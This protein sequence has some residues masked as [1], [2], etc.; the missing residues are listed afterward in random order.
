M[1]TRFVARTNVLARMA[2]PV[3]L[4]AGLCACSSMPDWVDPTGWFGSDSQADQTSDAAPDAAQIADNAQTP[5]LASIPAKPTAP[6]TPDEQKQ[7][8]E[9][10]AADRT[11]AQYSAEALEGGT[12]P[13]APP[14]PANDAAAPAASAPALADQTAST[15]PP[16]DT[17]SKAST[18]EAAASQTPAPSGT[19]AAQAPAAQMASTD[20]SGAAA[21]AAAAMTNMPSATSMQ[22]SFEPSH[23]PAL[24]PSVAHYVPQAILSRYQQTAAAAAPGVEGLAPATTMPRHRHHRKAKAAQTTPAPDTTAAPAQ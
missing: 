10:L 1:S 19:A 13:A 14:P 2:A 6:T 24:D 16:G 9:S 11:Q 12:E 18:T 21:P 5:D 3:L 4:A 22:A 8:T 15:A 17:A 23:A 7:V 20:S